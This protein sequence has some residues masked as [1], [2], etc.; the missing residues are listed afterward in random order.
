MPLAVFAETLE[1]AARATERPDFGLYFAQTFD[2]RS[3][4]ALGQLMYRAPTIGESL[5]AY[6][7]Y[8]GRIQSKTNVELQ[9]F[10]D[11]ASVSY[12]VQDSSIKYYRQDAEFSTGILLRFVSAACGTQWRRGALRFAHGPGASHQRQ[13]R[14]RY[15]T[16]FAVQPVFNAQ[17]N[18][19]EFPAEFLN[20]ANPLADRDLAEILQAHMELQPVVEM[21]ATGFAQRLRALLKDELVCG[22]G[23]S[24]EDVT[25]LLG[26][27]MR[28][29]QRNC[30]MQGLSFRDVRNEAVMTVAMDWLK[31]TEQSVTE[32]ALRLGFSETSSFSRAFRN[33]TG[34][35]PSQLRN[36]PPR[37]CR[38]PQLVRSRV[39]DKQD[40]E[41]I[42]S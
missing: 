7:A 2:M 6:V 1:K 25:R 28:S 31:N 40:D 34:F 26:C 14:C 22:H 17:S 9:V 33:S 3:F 4:G 5:R 18:C 21:G 35:T 39:Y 19:V 23:T 42:F 41:Q 8:Y 15:P 12:Q 38:R 10:G 16:P 27:S 11:L 30:A 32:I 29:L 24:I 37:L 20:V 36:E 13:P